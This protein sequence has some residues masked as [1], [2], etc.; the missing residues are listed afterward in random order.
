MV[1]IRNHQRSAKRTRFISVLNQVQHLCANLATQ[2][3]SKKLVQLC[4]KKLCAYVV[5]IRNL[6]P[7]TRNTPRVK[8]NEVEIN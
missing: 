4:V 5:K 7:E 3:T 8:S 6:K 1:K 2:T